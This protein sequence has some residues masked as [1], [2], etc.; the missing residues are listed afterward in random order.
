MENVG[1]GYI[2]KQLYIGYLPPK[3]CKF[4][5]SDIPSLIMFLILCIL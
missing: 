3:K 1:E 2:A 4:K 5:L